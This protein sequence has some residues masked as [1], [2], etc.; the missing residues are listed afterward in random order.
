MYTKKLCAVIM[1]AI[2]S[3]TSLAAIPVSAS[4]GGIVLGVNGLDTYGNEGHS[5]ILT[6]KTG[7]SVP[8]IGS[9][10]TWWRI[11]VFEYSDDADAYVV[12]ALSLT[13]SGSAPKNAYIPEDGFVLAV[14]LGNDYGNIDYRNEI[15]AS[16]YNALE[17]VKIGD[18]AYLVGLDLAAGRIDKSSL[19]H[20]DNNFT[21][22]A[23]IY[24]NESPANAD[25]YKPDR[26]PVRLERVQL[27]L[28][29]GDVIS[30][31]RDWTISWEEVEGAEYYLVNI[32]DGVSGDIG[33]ALLS[34]SKVIGTSVTIP[35]SKLVVG[36]TYRIGVS[37]VANGYRSSFNTDIK[38]DAVSD[39]AV[40][41]PFIGKRIVAFGDSITAFTGWVKMLGGELGTRVV[42]AGVG[43]NTTNDAV[44]RIKSDVLDRDPDIVIMMFGMNDQAVVLNTG[45]ALV[46]LTVFERNYCKMIEKML[47]QDI[48]VVLMTGHEVCTDNNYYVAGQYGLD[49]GTGN[50]D[51]YYDVIRKLASEYHLNLIDLTA[52]SEAET[53]AK[54]CAV[55][56][57]IHL[58]TYGHEMYSK[59]IGDFMYTGYASGMGLESSE[60][61]SSEEPSSEAE[62]SDISDISEKATSEESSRTVSRVSDAE[63]AK[64]E[65]N[66]FI[67]GSI[68]LVAALTFLAFFP[69]KIRK[70]KN[71]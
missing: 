6:R 51:N 19:D 33:N 50:I 56:D 12:T 45:N 47:A 58:S 24:I 68:G 57:G 43:G 34:N 66:V 17:K 48:D 22:N 21:T 37:A 49:Y 25:I 9:Y 4:D 13:A 16:T 2:L 65:K 14:N 1:A 41:S 36:Y 71:K 42:N 31:S 52:R 67:F 10:F 63:H 27:D 62:S 54:M 5:L 61:Q 7:M 11:A 44:S 30:A 29:D 8:N 55:G 53:R 60:E 59:W 46:S 39:R 26:S 20:W 28:K 38:A 70:K 23:Y 18:K 15:A 40:N 32:N 69:S 64:L 35:A 3:I